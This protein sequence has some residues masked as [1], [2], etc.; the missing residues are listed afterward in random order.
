MIVSEMDSNQLQSP[1][2]ESDA[3]AQ[4]S[5]SNSDTAQERGGDNLPIDHTKLQIWFV[6]AHYVKETRRL[7][8]P[9]A[10]ESEAETAE[11]AEPAE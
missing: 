5:K 4:D 8:A 11:P 10:H 1:T 2:L 6:K 9:E 7:S 3:K